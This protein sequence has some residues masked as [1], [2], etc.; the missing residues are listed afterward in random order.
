MLEGALVMSATLGLF[1]FI[2]QMGTFLAQQQYYAERARA[3]ARYA[4]T[5]SFSSSNTTPIKNYVCY[6]ST[7][8]PS[9]ATSGMFNL[10]PSMVTVTRRG[11]ANTWNDRIEV[12]IAAT[13]MVSHIPLLPGTL[14]GKTI[15][16][17]A[18]TQSLGATF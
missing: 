9:G 1:V 5:T 4:V 17:T 12:S 2:L 6:G 8:A 14:S 16:A 15:V 7:T 18:P 10:Q 13:S 3:G 11:T